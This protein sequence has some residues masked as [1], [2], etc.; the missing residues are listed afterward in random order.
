MGGGALEGEGGLA[1]EEE[2]EQEAFSEHNCTF[3]N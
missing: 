3:L 2:E 1:A